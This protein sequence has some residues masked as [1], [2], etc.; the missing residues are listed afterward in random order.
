MNVS[1]NL[2]TNTEET[3]VQKVNYL[4]VDLTH[5]LVTIVHGLGDV[6]TSYKYLKPF[7]N[8]TELV[9]MLFHFL[10]FTTDKMSTSMPSLYIVIKMV[11]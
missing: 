6:M 10:N 3:T 8:I 7:L 1:S 9:S 11:I 4:A 2:I 5:I